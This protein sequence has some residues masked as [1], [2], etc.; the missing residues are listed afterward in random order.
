MSGLRHSCDT[1]R[2]MRLAMH[3]L[4][5]VAGPITL[6]RIRSRRKTQHYIQ[7]HLLAQ[8]T[9]GLTGVGECAVC[10]F[11]TSVERF[12]VIISVRTIDAAIRDR[13]TVGM[14]VRN[15]GKMLR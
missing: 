13:I 8:I 10:T 1:P 7:H 3:G 6:I 5:I 2:K 14:R 12:V 9:H 11:K 15:V 4:N